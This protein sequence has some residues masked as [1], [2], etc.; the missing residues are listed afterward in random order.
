MEVV[1]VGHVNGVLEDGPVPALELDLPIHRLPPAGVDKAS[2]QKHI[3]TWTIQEKSP[4]RK[5]QV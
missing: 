3:E 1:D 2:S 4:D 5:T